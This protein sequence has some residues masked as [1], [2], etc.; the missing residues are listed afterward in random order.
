M[1][2]EGNIIVRF[3]IRN[4]TTLS[5]KVLKRDAMFFN[6]TVTGEDDEKSRS[7]EAFESFATVLVGV[8]PSKARKAE[9]LKCLKSQQM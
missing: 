5:T 9:R 4:Y 2:S 7:H 8:E 1:P 3:S 6:I